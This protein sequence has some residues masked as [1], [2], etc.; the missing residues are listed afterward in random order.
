MI[1]K[2]VAAVQDR[3]KVRCRSQ[4][5]SKANLLVLDISAGG[6]MVAYEGWKSEPGERVLATL[7]GLDARPSRLVWIEDGKAGIAFDEPLHPAVY[8]LLMSR[9]DGSFVDHAAR[10]ADQQRAVKSERRLHTRR[11]LA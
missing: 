3:L 10:S 11:S 7:H 4:S 8:D 2:D 9:L 1:V 5:G 6:C